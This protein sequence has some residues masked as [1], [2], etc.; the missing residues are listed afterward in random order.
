MHVDAGRIGVEDDHYRR[1][2][3]AGRELGL[4]RVLALPHDADYLV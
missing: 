2:L 1:L 4:S 3:F